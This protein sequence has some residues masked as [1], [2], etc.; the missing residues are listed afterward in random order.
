MGGV[1]LELRLECELQGELLDWVI[2]ETEAIPEEKFIVL[3]GSIVVEEL[4]ACFKPVTFKTPHREGLVWFE[5]PLYFCSDGVVE[6]VNHGEEYGDCIDL[7]QDMRGD[8]CA[9]REYGSR[10]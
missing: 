4:F 8:E 3:L 6:D 2:F 5:V 7:W 1:L 9:R 10:P